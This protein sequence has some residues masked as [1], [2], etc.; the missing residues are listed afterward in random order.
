[1]IDTN[2]LLQ[3]NVA[4][5]ARP[6]TETIR[7]LIVFG[8][9]Q[10]REDCASPNSLHIVDELFSMWGT[11]ALTGTPV[12]DQVKKYLVEHTNMPVVL[13]WPKSGL[14]LPQICVVAQAENE[15]S[16]QAYIGDQTG[17][18]GAGVGVIRDA[19]GNITGEI[20]DNNIVQ[21]RQK[22][23]VVNAQTGVF[24]RAKDPTLCVYF[25]HIVR[26]IIFMNK[27]EL[28]ENG[29]MHNLTIDVEEI[30]DGQELFPEFAYTRMISLKYLTAFDYNLPQEVIRRL[31]F[32][33]LINPTTINP[34]DGLVHD[35]RA[36]PVPP[37]KV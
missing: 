17:F 14:S 18:I 24:V 13:N 8:F 19:N 32:S 3:P 28:I 5:G 10:L 9:Q 1:M 22:G 36:V 7:Q 29:D 12:V 11:D 16:E 30:V 23:M 2:T 35:E 4:S 26:L 15:N 6:T 33:L 25:A 27:L 37:P 20:A 34:A 21:R 31:S